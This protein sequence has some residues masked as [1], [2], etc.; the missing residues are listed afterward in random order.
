MEPETS[1]IDEGKHLRIIAELPGIPEGKIRIDLEKTTVTI[2]A[3]DAGKQ[4]N[5]VI[6]IP[7]EAR[8]FKKRFLD[9]VLELNLE[10]TG[11]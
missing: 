3:S 7:C 1:L 5:K 11:S 4:Y 2:F 6:T 8:L 10:K 9:G